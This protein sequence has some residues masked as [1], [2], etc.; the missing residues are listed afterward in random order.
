M[1]PY[2]LNDGTHAADVAFRDV[3]ATNEDLIG[4]LDEGFEPLDSAVD[5][6][7]V[8]TATETWGR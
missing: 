3:H 2:R 4:R 7:C 8:A 5:C 6:T 1:T